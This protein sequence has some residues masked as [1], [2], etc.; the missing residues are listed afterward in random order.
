ML[1]GLFSDI[2]PILIAAGGAIVAFL[3]YGARQRSKGRRE[4]DRKHKEA[5]HEKAANIR[6]LVERERDQ[7]LRDH[8]GDGWRD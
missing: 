3:G 5:D 8:D 6:N 7:R 1:G 4:Q 2:W